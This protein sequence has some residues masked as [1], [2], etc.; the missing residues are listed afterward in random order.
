[1]YNYTTF[2]S[3]K[4]AEAMVANPARKMILISM[5]SP[6]TKGCAPAVLHDD[7]W[8]G[9]LRLEYH[10]IDYHLKIK[11]AKI[12]L[13]LFGEEHALEIMKFLK[14]HEAAEV[15]DVIVHCEAGI[16][17]SAAV[18]KFVSWLYRL[19][20]PE[21]YSLYNKRVFSTLLSLYGKCSYGEGPL[22][23]EDLPG[24]RK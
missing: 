2:V 9:V 21:H 22:Q 12:D 3:K 4:V 6:N 23:V 13:V 14:E 5:T 11:E 10:D 8:Q 18:S 7:A 15:T 24:W 16:S 20:F 1:M 19:P 17:R